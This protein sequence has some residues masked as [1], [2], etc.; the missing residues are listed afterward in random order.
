MTKLWEI[1]ETRK[2]ERKIPANI[3]KKFA[4]S[5]IKNTQFE[6]KSSYTGG[7]RA[8]WLWSAVCSWGRSISAF[9]RFGAHSKS[10]RELGGLELG[11]LSLSL[12]LCN[13]NCS[14]R[15]L[16]HEN[17]STSRP[18]SA[19]PRNWAALLI[20]AN[21][22]LLGVNLDGW[23]SHPMQLPL[24]L[25]G[26]TLQCDFI[27]TAVAGDGQRNGIRIERFRVNESTAELCAVSIGRC[28]RRHRSGGVKRNRTGVRSLN[29]TRRWAK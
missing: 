12:S 18:F 6:T 25:L 28:H 17:Y 11:A 1:N 4:H 14:P 16:R 15:E 22:E 29:R 21:I 20:I 23:Y 26:G 27:T 3:K 10:S 19:K 5:K 8:R 13:E 24:I 7:R 2:R 9:G